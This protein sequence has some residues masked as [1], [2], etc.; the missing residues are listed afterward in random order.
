M[1]DGA[2][3]L[4]EAL[5]DFFE[6][7]IPFNAWLGMKVEQVGGGRARVRVPFRPELVGDPLRPALHGGVLSALAD[8]AGGLAAW[9]ALPDPSTGRLATVD[10]RVDYLR[11]GRLEDLVCD[12]ELVRLGNRVAVTKMALWQAG[13][14]GVAEAR[15]VYNVVRARGAEGT[16][17]G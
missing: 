11:P 14:H 9:G 6:H 15:A 4:P 17:A 8:T 13:D 16:A 3:P 12:A 5:L 7:R 10:L 2:S 1:T